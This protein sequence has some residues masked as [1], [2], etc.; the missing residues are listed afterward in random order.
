M[1]PLRNQSK[2]GLNLATAAAQFA[3]P[4]RVEI[5]LALT[6]G[7]KRTAGEL[8]AIA[9]ISPSTASGH[10]SGLLDSGLLTLERRGQ[11]RFYRLAG[12]QVKTALDSLR[13]LAEFGRV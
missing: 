1:P 3:V 6:D 12:P 9:E 7:E 5:L 13:S 2:A 11:R 8:A 4:A 10:L